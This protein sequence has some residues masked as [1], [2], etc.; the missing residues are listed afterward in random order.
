MFKN[1]FSE[2]ILEDEKTSTIR[3]KA[4]C[5]KGDIL[6]LRM[7]SGKPYRSKHIIIKDAVCKEIHKVFIDEQKIIVNE[8][9]FTEPFNGWIAECEGFED[10]D[11]MTE[12]FKTTHGL[13]FQ[14]DLIYWGNEPF[15]G[16]IGCKP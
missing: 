7:W 1:R 9:T 10:W 4:R 5:K 3:P 14:G 8:T 13:P 12:F 2:K 15:I 16:G 6:S 11:S